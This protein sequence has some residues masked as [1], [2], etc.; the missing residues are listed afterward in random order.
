MGLCLRRLL[1]AVI[2]GRKAP[3]RGRA[4]PRHRNPPH[5]LLARLGWGTLTFLVLGAGLAQAA[6]YVYDG[7]GRLRAVTN[8][9]GASAEYVYDGMGNLLQVE[10]VPTGKLAIFAFTPSHGAVGTSVTISGQ[11]FSATG[12]DDTVKFN[13]TVA[14]VTAATATTLST[15][16]PDGATTGTIS[17][18][19]GTAT[20]TSMDIF[21]V[22]A[23][24]QP[25]V[26][27][28]FS[29]TIA[30]PG[31]VVTVTG[32]NLDPVP[33][34]SFPA[35]GGTKAY[36]T[37]ASQ[38]QVVFSVPFDACSAPVSITTPF[39]TGVSSSSLIVTP[40]GIN[41]AQVGVRK[42][43]SVGASIPLSVPA[44]QY[45]LV[46]FNATTG[47]YLSF[48]ASNGVNSSNQVNYQIY[49]ACNQKI[50][51]SSYFYE[52]GG[53][54]HLP[55]IP[56]T[57]AYFIWFNSTAAT[58]FTLALQSDPLLPLNQVKS[59]S[60]AVLGQTQRVL[61]GGLTGQSLD[62]QIE[63]QS[64]AP[65]GAPVMYNV[66]APDGSQI[67][68][69]TDS[70]GPGEEWISNLPSTGT[71]SILVAP[72]PTATVISQIELNDTVANIKPGGS[73]NLN[74]TAG[75][76][77]PIYVSFNITSGGNYGLGINNLN[78]SPD[79]SIGVGV[80]DSNNMY[81]NGGSCF[82]S[83]GGCGVDLPN[84]AVGSYHALLT[85]P[86][87]D[88]I[89]GVVTLTKDA[90]GTLILNSPESINLATRGQ[91][92]TY[93]FNGT[94][95]Q[96]VALN[97]S[98]P[99]TN[100][101]GNLITYTITAPDGTQYSYYLNS[102]SFTLDL[103]SLLQSG[104]YSVHIV[105]A[106]GATLTESLELVPGMVT[107]VTV[108]GSSQNI[109]TLPGQSAYITF[110]ANPGDNIGL[111]ISGLVVTNDDDVAVS[112]Y[113][114]NG[115]I[116]AKNEY[117]PSAYG[118]CALDLRNLAGGQYQIV[119]GVPGYDYNYTARFTAA[120]SHDVS[121]VLYL[122][123]PTSVVL[124]RRGMTAMY[125]FSGTAGQTL[126]IGISNQ[127]TPQDGS[128]FFT[129]TAPD[130][131]FYENFGSGTGTWNLPNLPESG[132]Y[133]VYVQPGLETINNSLELVLG[134]TGVLE[135]NGSPQNFT[136]SSPG[137]NVY[138]N[139]SVN[140]I[141]S[142]TLGIS[143]LS[144]SDL[145]VGIYDSNGNYEDIGGDCLV[146]SGSCTFDLTGLQPGNYQAIAIPGNSTVSFT[147][148]L[149]S[150]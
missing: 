143:D 131:K 80:Y 40:A 61:F 53:S 8:S 118:G 33:K 94:K 124:P 150:Q 87:N 69:Y 54:I 121:G 47:S 15:S 146:S 109:N 9:T 29:P 132:T 18:T 91:A 71:Y 39:G 138:M 45:G 137:E 21:T 48:Q 7:N 92:G 35:I 20:A 90:S 84:L 148:T 130:G 82:V 24:G 116:V 144:G 72:N 135:V 51:T 110:Q 17:V 36:A 3:W 68:T 88:T 46:Q 119:I 93:K 31:T 99:A 142:L 136:T 103:G 34:Q 85:P 50:M 75:E 25:P 11:G 37:S 111:G 120:L 125:T 27:T 117:C 107:P 59:V 113:D 52:S 67:F 4:Y 22:D 63:S 81:L 149:T 102:S 101:S 49:N 55:K 79:S 108:D 58:N 16:V 44:N 105:P 100:P 86:G 133:Q 127:G 74:A 122:N 114:G 43:I 106:I 1:D 5:R 23:T 19:V 66:N 76:H 26:V 13:G 97:V 98:N 112:V 57:G 141:E 78:V 115:N 134:V 41:V 139:F 83:D 6:T 64:T 128:A 140:T 145:S 95:G 56:A 104:T 123:T 60:T 12:A 38:T 129:A 147:A 77:D 32:Q 30:S 70:T 126:A 62:F 89:K 28:S 10:S 65:S 73:L 96:V 42:S 14:T 2:P